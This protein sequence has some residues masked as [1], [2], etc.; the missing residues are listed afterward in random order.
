MSRV[1]GPGG[2]T[3]VPGL[4]VP[5]LAKHFYPYGR[6][7][8]VY[9][10]K[11]INGEPFGFILESSTDLGGIH[12][13][14][15]AFR[16]ALSKP[17]L[18]ALIATE[19]RRIAQVSE[20]DRP[21]FEKRRAWYQGLLA[22]DPGPEQWLDESLRITGVLVPT[23]EFARQHPGADFWRYVDAGTGGCCN[24]CMESVSGV[25]FY[26]AS[27]HGTSLSAFQNDPLVRVVAVT[28]AVPKGGEEFVS[29]ELREQLSK[30]ASFA[31]VCQANQAQWAC[32]DEAI[33][34]L[35]QKSLLPVV[36]PALREIGIIPNWEKDA[37]DAA[38]KW[39]RNGILESELKVI[40]HDADHE[41]FYTPSLTVTVELTSDGEV[42][43][44]SAFDTIR[45][46]GVEK[47]LLPEPSAADVFLSRVI[48]LD[49]IQQKGL[50]MPG[51]PV[52]FDVYK[53]AYGASHEQAPDESREAW[54][55]RCAEQD[56]NDKDH[57]GCLLMEMA[58]AAEE[59]A[60]VRQS[61]KKVEVTASPSAM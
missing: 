12:L 2:L 28:A 47:R 44:F 35:L 40:Y 18:D 32:N 37:Y 41:I 51:E 61:R 15:M 27:L 34:P 43:A 48:A 49:C 55:S 30:Y 36:D 46:R 24:G 50:Q 57:D 3:P 10:S 60:R 9:V 4:S 56:F 20:E 53:T 8:L 52:V 38:P 1:L 13:D 31:D 29:P 33:N 22:G 21:Y 54:L 45:R 17:S 16:M 5:I 59:S 25:K 26:E 23:E 6:E 14:N 39:V 19:D 42:A 11:V 58:I 7:K